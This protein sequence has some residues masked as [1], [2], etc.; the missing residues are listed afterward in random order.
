VD[1]SAVPRLPPRRAPAM[2]ENTAAVLESELGLDAHDLS[3][4]RA[5]GVIA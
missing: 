1:F 3:K 2:G 5:E 4:L